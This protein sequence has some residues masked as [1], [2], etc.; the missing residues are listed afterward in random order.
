MTRGAE[1]TRNSAVVLNVYGVFQEK[2]TLG[3]IPLVVKYTYAA[4]AIFW[5][6]RLIDWTRIA[7][8]TT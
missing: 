5:F 8:E 4:E 7:E 6:F 1:P 3:I 2:Q